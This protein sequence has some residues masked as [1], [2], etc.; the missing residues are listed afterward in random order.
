MDSGFSLKL[1]KFYLQEATLFAKYP[2]ATVRHA[3]ETRQRQEAAS[4]SAPEGEGD[5][6]VDWEGDSSRAR[7]EDAAGEAGEG[8]QEAA[9]AS[10]PE[11]ERD[12]AP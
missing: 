3:R 10:A 1:F 6:A 12:T 9:L 7:G 2:C 8:C 11:G 4:A 5:T